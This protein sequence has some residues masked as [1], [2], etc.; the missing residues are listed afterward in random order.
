M[1]KQLPPVLPFNEIGLAVQQNRTK[2][3][4][5]TDK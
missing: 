5:F 1:E 2:K 3:S 4:E